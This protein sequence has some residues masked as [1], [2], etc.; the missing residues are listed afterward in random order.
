VQ[1]PA[2]VILQ[3]IRQYWTYTAVPLPE[4]ILTKLN[5]CSHTCQEIYSI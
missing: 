5:D 1:D 3:T 2:S 4:S